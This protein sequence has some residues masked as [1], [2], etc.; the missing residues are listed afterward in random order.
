MKNAVVALVVVVGILGG[1]YG[2]Y[3]VG[4]NNASAGAATSSNTRGNGGVFTQGRG[5]LT[6]A[7]PSPGATPST[8][9]M[10][11]ARGTITNLSASSMTVSNTA[12][13]VTVKF[14]TTTAVSKTVP[15]STSDL[16]DNQ[17]VTVTGTRQADGSILAQSIQV[18][19]AGATRG[20]GASPGAG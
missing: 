5:G 9:S 6:S 8:G 18:G 2:G 12:C 11:F 19:G 3:K 4:Q 14:T 20:P 13:D 1:F 7:C 15:A 10:T 16:D 17:T